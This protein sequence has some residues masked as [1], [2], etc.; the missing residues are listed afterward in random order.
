MK[1]KLSDGEWALMKVL[2]KA[3]PMTITQLTAA[4]KEETRFAY[5][6]VFKKSLYSMLGC[7]PVLFWYLPESYFW[8]SPWMVW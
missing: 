8:Y 2:W 3:S 6:S 4:L 5:L 7:T 1:T